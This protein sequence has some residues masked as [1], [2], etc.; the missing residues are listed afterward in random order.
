MKKGRIGGTWVRLRKIEVCSVLFQSCCDEW[1]KAI[2]FKAI[3]HLMS[4][5]SEMDCCTSSCS[6][7]MCGQCPEL[8]LS[9]SLFSVPR[10]TVRPKNAELADEKIGWSGA[11]ELRN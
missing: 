6:I 7:P 10:N 3:F 4:L 5:V 1:L 9:L 11:E 2:T 8:T